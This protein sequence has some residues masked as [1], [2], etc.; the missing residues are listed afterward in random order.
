M[1]NTKEELLSKIRIVE[2]ARIELKAVT[3]LGKR[4]SGSHPDVL[5]DEIAAFA[6]SSG[7][8]I[9]LGVDEQASKPQGISVGELTVLEYWLLGICNDRIKPPPLCRI[10]KWRLPDIADIPSPVLKVE[11]PRSLYVHESRDQLKKL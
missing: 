7:G 4:V 10:E 2:D 9:I 1:F 6:N 3:F 5:A 8:V 11:I